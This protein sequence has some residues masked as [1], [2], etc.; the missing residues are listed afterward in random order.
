MRQEAISKDAGYGSGDG[1]DV[2]TNV[3]QE[4]DE[5]ALIDAIRADV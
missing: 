5:I 3:L 1:V 2:V 4:S